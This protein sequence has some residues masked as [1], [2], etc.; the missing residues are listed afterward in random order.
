[1]LLKNTGIT[2]FLQGVKEEEKKLVK[3]LNSNLVGQLEYVRDY[4]NTR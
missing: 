2:I 1:M 3:I 4:C